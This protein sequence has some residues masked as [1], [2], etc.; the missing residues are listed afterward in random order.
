[1]NRRFMSYKE[2][3]FDSLY[4]MQSISL[5]LSKKEIYK[6]RKFSFFLIKRVQSTL[7]LVKSTLLVDFVTK[8]TWILHEFMR[9]AWNRR[10]H[11]E[12]KILGI[13]SLLSRNQQGNWNQA[14]RLI[15]KWYL[16][17]PL[18]VLKALHILQ[19]LA[20]HPIPK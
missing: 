14:L 1:M 10:F 5:F 6:E 8:D 11:Q 16:Q 18:L 13:S 7:Y 4:E 19:N 3:I 20:Y 9:N 2:R 15:L 17:S 12:S